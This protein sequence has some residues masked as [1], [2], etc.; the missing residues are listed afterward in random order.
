LDLTEPSL[1]F[2]PAQAARLGGC[3]RSQLGHWRRSGVVVPS[4]ADGRYSFRDLVGLRVVVSLL[5][6]GL[7][8][9]RVKA[10]LA[11]LR[12]AGD[13]AGSDP[14]S[15]DL[16]GLR[17]VTDGV[18]VFA[19]YDDGQILDALRNGQLA[20]FVAV[21]RFASAL[22]A[23]IEAFTAER[24][25]FLARLRSGSHAAVPDCIPSDR[26]DDDETVVGGPVVARVGVAR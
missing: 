22:D 11:V 19:C 14:A 7:P 9:V 4:E 26:R 18:S 16:A 2:V 1:G 17:I 3:T 12:T 10:A 25:A 6:A 8:M 15:K 23:D 13:P 21:D 5:E 20:L 24:D